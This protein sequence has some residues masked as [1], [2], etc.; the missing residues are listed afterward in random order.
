MAW[1]TLYKQKLKS[2]AGAAGCVASGDVIY[3]GVAACCPYT[4][5]DALVDR[6]DALR[7]VTVTSLLLLKACKLVTTPGL[8]GK[9]NH[10]TL[11]YGG[12]DKAGFANGSTAINPVHFSKT[13]YALEH[14]HK[15]NTLMVPGT[16][17]DEQGYIDLGPL[18]AAW[19]GPVADYASKIIIS[20]NPKLP[21]THGVKNTIHISRVHCLC[22]CEEELAALSQPQVTAVDEAIARILVD[23][24]PDGACIQIGLGGLSNA[25]GYALVNKKH[26]SVHTEMLTDSMVQLA[27]QGVISGPIHAGFGLG[28]QEVYAFCSNEQ[29]QLAP[30]PHINSLEQ[31]AK[32]DN[33]ISINACLMA[34]LT[35]QV[36]SESIGFTQFSSVGGQ[37]DFVRGAALSRGGKSFLCLAS[38]MKGK[39]GTVQSKINVS[40]PE[41]AVVTTPRSDAMYIVTEYGIADVFCKSI[42][43]RALAMIAIAHPDFRATLREQAVRHGLIRA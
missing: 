4:L 35:G 32:N 24:I 23:Q 3:A 2:V 14:V 16:L 29:V 11:F 33:F 20:V 18:G 36:G 13:G 41:G 30:I 9:I 40:L 22:E 7:N 37:V 10:V 21:R 8:D 42:E 1:K 27:K 19:A 25:I 12:A 6:A 5:L 15:V 39:D 31:V 17:P 38:T 34:D 28:S 26:L 43:A